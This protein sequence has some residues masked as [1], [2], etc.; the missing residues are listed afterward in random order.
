MSCLLAVSLVQH[1]IPDAP[2]AT[3][4]AV[5]PT[6]NL[7][8]TLAAADTQALPATFTSAPA[9]APSVPAI[10][11]L[12][13]GCGRQID[14]VTTDITSWIEGFNFHS[15]HNKF[16]MKDATVQTDI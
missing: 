15:L 4:F 11:Q 10:Y 7:P 5:P 1:H 12:Q 2:A 9:V 3:T 8:C 14:I 6:Q 16:N 13:L